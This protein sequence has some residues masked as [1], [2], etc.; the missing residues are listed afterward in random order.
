MSLPTTL[1]G[2]AR[3]MYSDVPISPRQSLSSDSR[4]VRR[5]EAAPWPPGTP[6][7]DD[8]VGRGCRCGVQPPTYKE[9]GVTES[10][11]GSAVSRNTMTANSSTSYMR[12]SCG[13]SYRCLEPGGIRRP[14][15]VG[16]RG[17]HHMTKLAPTSTHWLHCRKRIERTNA[18]SPV[19]GVKP[20]ISPVSGRGLVGPAG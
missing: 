2:C 3:N 14:G 13:Q 20:T 18:P 11:T 17:G 19:G 9:G 15:A 10:L 4:D 5:Q 6:G 7:V 16:E 1:H 12:G 8:R